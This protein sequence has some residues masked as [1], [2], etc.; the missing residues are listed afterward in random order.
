MQ[1]CE[2]QP[3]DGELRFACIG[4]ADQQGH[5]DFVLTQVGGLHDLVLSGDEVV[6]DVLLAARSLS[7]GRGSGERCQQQRDRT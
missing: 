1:T 6:A 7:A 4:Q 5:A 3:G 2:F